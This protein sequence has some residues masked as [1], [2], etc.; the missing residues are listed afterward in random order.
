MGTFHQNKHELHGI[1]CVI[2]TDGA[3]VYVGRVDD[4]DDDKVILH[5]VDVHREGDGGKTKEEYV[6]KAA[7]LGVFKKHDRLV[8][9][10]ARVTSIRRL[11]DL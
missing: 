8:V 5:D 10:Q 1:T 6:E 4:L 9:P 7:Q 11:G 2:D 3:E